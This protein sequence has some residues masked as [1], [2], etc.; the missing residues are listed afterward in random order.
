MLTKAQLEEDQCAVRQI[1]VGNDPIARTNSFKR[2]IEMRMAKIVS[3]EPKLWSQ[4][5]RGDESIEGVKMKL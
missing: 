4:F 5:V 2:W 3:H 1:F